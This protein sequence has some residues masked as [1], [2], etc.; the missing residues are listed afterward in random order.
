MTKED[1]KIKLSEIFPSATFEEGT[2]WLTIN[3]EAADWLT[4]ATA[5]RSRPA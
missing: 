5:L 1:L 3:A 2:E 4:L